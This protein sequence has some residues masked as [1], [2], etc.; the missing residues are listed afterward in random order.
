MA[1]FGVTWCD[2]TGVKEQMGAPRERE[3]GSGDVYPKGAVQFFQNGVMFE[4]PADRQVWV[5]VPDTGWQRAGY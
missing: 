2:R 3:F 1:G 5:L 4:S